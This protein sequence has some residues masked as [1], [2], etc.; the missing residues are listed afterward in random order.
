MKRFILIL[1]LTAVIL[2]L[3]AGGIL[4]H[5]SRTYMTR[6]TL[7]SLIESELNLRLEV[8]SVHWKVFTLS[9]VIRVE[10]VRIAARDDYV[11][12]GVP[13][14][15]R[16]PLQPEKAIILIPSAE[17]EFSLKPL[18]D[19]NRLKLV[20]FIFNKPV[21]RAYLARNG[22]LNVE[23]L[24]NKPP[25]STHKEDSKNI[26]LTEKWFRTASNKTGSN[27]SQITR[28]LSFPLA[29]RLNKIALVGG[30]LSLH[31]AETGH[32]FTATD[33]NIA[34]EKIDFDPGNL[35]E[36][37]Q[38]ELSVS[39]VLHAHTPGRG[40]VARLILSAYGSMNPL[41]DPEK[42]QLNDLFYLK[43]TLKKN[44]FLF[45]SA[46][47]DEISGELP[48][49]R[50][51]GFRLDSLKRKG[52]LTEDLNGEVL[53]GRG[54]VLLLNEF[55]FPVDD[56]T[57]YLN[58]SSYYRY[59]NDDHIFSGRIVTPSRTSSR[60]V[61]IMDEFLIPLIHPDYRNK[62]DD[63]R[64]MLMGD[65]LNRDG[66]E[67]RFRS[68]GDIDDP[69]VTILNRLPQLEKAASVLGVVLLKHVLR[70]L[71]ESMIGRETRRIADEI[72]QSEE[73]QEA[74]RT[75]EKIEQSEEYQEARRKANKIADDV[76]SRVDEESKEGGIID[77][78]G[79]FIEKEG[80]E[81]LDGIGDIFSSDDEEQDSP[82]K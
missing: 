11:K 76:E 67:I 1:T 41:I 56:F 16:P 19:E 61:K 3:L 53:V 78:T 24:F 66:I 28:I 48:A 17:A 59:S 55:H 30:R 20:H 43:L 33:A 7:V 36:H 4:Y 42:G 72:E 22:K 81:L 65:M 52:V 44:S 15:K 40:E 12:Q 46:I 6:D 29:T 58:K 69:K 45:R 38:A 9:P 57:L 21:I 2:L 27:D 54:R 79:K 51:I 32:R 50:Q 64:I 26:L 80:K 71:E 62:T 49:L 35:K 23:E 73:F 10:N 82:Q 18:I 60:V 63:L 47:L 37:N 75:A 14:S 70:E 25:G 39:G 13:F 8:E 31:V 34:I 5:L 77:K 74:K 68:T